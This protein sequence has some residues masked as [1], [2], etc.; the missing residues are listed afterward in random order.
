MMTHSQ[1]LELKR[2]N[3]PT[4]NNGWKQI[5]KRD[6]NREVLDLE[7]T[8]DFMPQM[9][10]MVGRAVTVRSRPGNPEYGADGKGANNRRRYYEYIASVDG[11]RIVVSCPAP[12]QTSST[13]TFESK[14]LS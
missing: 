8:T 3:T 1:M 14:S 9:E 10:P 13:V 6:S 4:I 7:E 11:P 5:T 12:C 2:W